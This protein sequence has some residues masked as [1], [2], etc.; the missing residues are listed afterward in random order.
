MITNKIIGTAP[1]GARSHSLSVCWSSPGSMTSEAISQVPSS[2][3]AM[4]VTRSPSQCSPPSPAE[5]SPRT[6]P[7]GVEL[8]PKLIARNSSFQHSQEMGPEHGGQQ[9][10]ADDRQDCKAL[11]GVELKARAGVHHQVTHARKQ[12]LKESPRQGDQPP[13]ENG[14]ARDRKRSPRH[15]VKDRDGHVR[16]PSPD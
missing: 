7:S 6:L 12:M 4:L 3:S 9:D 13:G 1:L 14:E 10:R 5:P 8:S 2:N 15:S 16:A 11:V